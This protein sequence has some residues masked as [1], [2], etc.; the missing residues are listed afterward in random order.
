MAD[1]SSWNR[2]ILR[3]LLYSLFAIKKWDLKTPGREDDDLE[4]EK[5]VELASDDYTAIADNS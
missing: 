4:A 2:S 5:K 1:H 3:I